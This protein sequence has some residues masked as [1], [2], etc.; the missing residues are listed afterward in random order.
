MGARGRRGAHTAGARKEVL[1]RTNLSR[2][3]RRHRGVLLAALGIAAAVLVT[4]LGLAPVSAAPAADRLAVVHTSA[5]AVRGSL[6]ADHR[7]FLGI[8][9]AAAPVGRLRWRAAQPVPAWRGI[10]D[11]TRPVKGIVGACRAGQKG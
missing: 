4:G 5:G 10:R 11:V 7:T 1:I 8:P 3:L 6:A 9:Y 2:R